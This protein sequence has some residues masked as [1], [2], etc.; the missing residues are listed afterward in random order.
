MHRVLFLATGRGSGIRSDGC[1]AVTTSLVALVIW[2][3]ADRSPAANFD[4]HA[5]REPRATQ[6]AEHAETV[7]QRAFATLLG[8]DD[9]GSWT[10]RCEIHLHESEE[11][12][13]EALGG[14]PSGARGATSIEFAGNDIILRRIDVIDDDPA[15]LPDALAHELVHMVL[16]D[17]FATAP[18]PRWADEGLAVLFDHEEK[19]AAHDGDFAAARRAGTIWSVSYLFAMEELPLEPHRQRVF[20]GQSAAL[21]RWLLTRGGP[22]T[23]VAFLDDA[24]TAGTGPALERH[25]GF[26][27]TA[28]LEREWLKS[29]SVTDVGID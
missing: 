18:P 27:S 10:V 15:V 11:A 9:P 25:Y 12:L 22:E 28:S 29:P 14:T 4:V 1:R 20:Y 8:V 7:R 23:L 16:A 3:A 19:R 2:A 24:A 13:A 17:R 6:V 21:V 5:A 26:A